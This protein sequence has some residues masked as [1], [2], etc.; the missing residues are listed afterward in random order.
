[1][2]AIRRQGRRLPQLRCWSCIA[3]LAWGFLRRFGVR[4]DFLFRPLGRVPFGK[5]RIA[6][7]PK[8]T[9]RSCPG[10]PVFRLGEKFP[11]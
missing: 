4:A 1:M 9:K 6:A 11:R 8:G 2:P 7:L 3:A 10:H 5:R